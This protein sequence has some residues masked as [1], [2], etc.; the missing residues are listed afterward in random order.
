MTLMGELLGAPPAPQFHGNDVALRA[1]SGSARCTWTC[2][3][4]LRWAAWP[5]WAFRHGRLPPQQAALLAQ[6]QARLEPYRG[7]DW[8]PTPLADLLDSLDTLVACRNSTFW[9]FFVSMMGLAVPQRAAAPLGRA[10]GQRCC[11]Q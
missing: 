8:T 11:F 3:R 9:L 2:L 4:C 1:P 6:Q 7:Q 10:A 5:D